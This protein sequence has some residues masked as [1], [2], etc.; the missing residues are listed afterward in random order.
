MLQSLEPACEARPTRQVNTTLACAGSSLRRLGV[1]LVFV[2]VY[3]A[4]GSLPYL[5][6]SSHHVLGAGRQWRRLGNET[7]GPLLEMLNGAGDASSEDPCMGA[8]IY[9]YDLRPF[10]LSIPQ[11]RRGLHSLYEWLCFQPRDQQHYC[12]PS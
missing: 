6:G 2:G 1:L 12:A 4:V 5:V 10:N 8:R 7:H 3:F 11:V 9:V